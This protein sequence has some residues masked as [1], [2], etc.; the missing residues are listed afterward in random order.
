M[1]RGDPSEEHVSDAL[2]DVAI[3]THDVPER[4]ANASVGV[5]LVMHG[6]ADIHG[7]I[8]VGRGF[9]FRECRALDGV[10][11]VHA[12]TIHGFGCCAHFVCHLANRPR[13]A[14]TS[15]SYSTLRLRRVIYFN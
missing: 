13:A 1:E 11:V 8:Q 10:E 5:G 12:S 14:E 4:I 3:L 2:A 7:T 15:T 9:H 6:V